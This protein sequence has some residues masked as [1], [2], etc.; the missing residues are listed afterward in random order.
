MTRRLLIT[1]LTIS[2]LALAALAIPLGITFAQR[3][4]DRLYF[5]IERDA[6]AVS[7]LSEDALENGTPL[8]L[9]ATL[10]HYR[11]TTRGRIVVVDK[12]GKSVADSNDPN[13]PA[14][15]YSNRPEIASALQGRRAS[16]TRHSNTAGGSLVYVAIPVASGASC[17][18]R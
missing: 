9:E 6:S 18:V 17:T 16:G 3:E 15:N 4:R 13:T 8:P 11:E 2:A 10:A 1:Y 12:T 7:A 5:E 14:E